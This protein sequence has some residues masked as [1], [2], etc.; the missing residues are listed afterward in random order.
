M[1]AFGRIYNGNKVNVVVD[2]FN[3]RSS[4]AV[5]IEGDKKYV[6]RSRC[7]PSDK[8]N[9]ELGEKL[10]IGRA[11]KKREKVLLKRIDNFK[12][13]VHKNINDTHNGIMYRW[14]ADNNKVIQ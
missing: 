10:A 2:S 11:L 4:K 8:F 6:G 1:L 7:H 13:Q 12:K 3:N 9:K 5:I 14:D